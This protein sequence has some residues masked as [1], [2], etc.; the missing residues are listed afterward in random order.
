ML[1]AQW[2][3]YMDLMAQE[4]H[5]LLEALHYGCYLRS[6]KTHLPKK[7]LRQNLTA[8]ELRSDLQ[9]RIASIPCISI[10]VGIKRR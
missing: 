1:R 3:L 8:L 6:F 7:L 9:V 4:K 10:L 2:Y 5:R